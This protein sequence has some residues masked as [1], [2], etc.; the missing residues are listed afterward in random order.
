MVLLA[1]GFKVQKIECLLSLFK[2]GLFK[3]Y[4]INQKYSIFFLL[5]PWH[6]YNVYGGLPLTFMI[7]DITQMAEKQT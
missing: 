6:L 3:S 5:L 7:V 4:H 2:K 1:K